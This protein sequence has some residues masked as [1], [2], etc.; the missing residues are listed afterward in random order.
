MQ[1]ILA[2]QMRPAITLM[3]HTH[4]PVTVDTMVMEQTALVSKTIFNL[5]HQSNDNSYNFIKYQSISK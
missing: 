5:Q 3:D 2:M 4:V 1:L